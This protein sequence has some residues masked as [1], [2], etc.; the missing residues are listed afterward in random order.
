MGLS[1]EVAGGVGLGVSVAVGIGLG[2]GEAIEVAVAVGLGV[3]VAVDVTVA[4]GPGVGEAV[5]VG[6]AIG[7]T[8]GGGG[9]VAAGTGLPAS[10]PFASRVAEG[11]AV[12]SGGCRMFSASRGACAG[13]GAAK[14]MRTPPGARSRL[15]QLPAKVEL[16]ESATVPSRTAP[17]V[18]TRNT[19]RA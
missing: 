15:A 17:S 10:W 13:T 3:G 4:V 19:L 16:S 7:L 2:V 14:P 12:V 18:R 1:V 11:V 8:A 6:V 5:E 9:G